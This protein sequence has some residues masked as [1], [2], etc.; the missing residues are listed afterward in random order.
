MPAEEANKHLKE[1]ASVYATVKEETCNPYKN[2]LRTFGVIQQAA[3]D[4]VKHFKGDSKALEGFKAAIW[5]P[6]IDEAN[7]LEGSGLLVTAV[8]VAK[9]KVVTVQLPLDR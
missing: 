7:K 4:I 8:A 9:T 6:G 2:R 1:L 3:D 5:G